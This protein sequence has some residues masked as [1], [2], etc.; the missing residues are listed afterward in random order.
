MPTCVMRSCRLVGVLVEGQV[1]RLQLRRIDRRRPVELL[2]SGPRDLQPELAVNPEHEAAAIERVGSFGAPDVGRADLRAGKFDRL[3]GDACRVEVSVA[4]RDRQHQ[5]NVGPEVVVG[6][7]RSVHVG[8]RAVRHEVAGHRGDAVAEVVRV[9]DA[10]AV[11]VNAVGRPGAR[12]ELA[13]ADR[14]GRARAHVR[15]EAALDLEMAARICQGM[16]VWLL[17]CCMTARWS[18]GISA[19]AAGAAF[20][21]IASGRPPNAAIS[22]STGAN[23]SSASG[24]T[25][26]MASRP[27]SPKMSGASMSSGSNMFVSRF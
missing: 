22:R 10:V 19:A 2:L 6:V 14:A 7:E 20:V 24:P 9:G 11:P 27:R 12:H 8:G 16:P 5:L 25:T 21:S 15:A 1:A 18:G 23:S 4:R 26:F 13:V 3:G 17:T